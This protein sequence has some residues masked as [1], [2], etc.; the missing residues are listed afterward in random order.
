MARVNFED[1]VEAQDEFW[2]LL[3]LV[4]GD[5]DSALGKLVR[6]FRLA[7]KAY[8]HDRPMT[9]DE[10]RSRGFGIM[11]ES[12]WAV[13]VNGGYQALGAPKHF[14][15]YRQKVLAGKK[16]GRPIEENEEP[17]GNLS[18]PAD[19]LVV[20]TANPLAPAPALALSPAPAQKNKHTHARE[21]I[22]RCIQEWKRTLEHFEIS[23]PIGERD[24]IEIAR[25][26][27]SFGEEWVKLAFQGA[28]K[29]QA[30]KRFDP[31]L[32]VSLR[33]YLHKDRIERLVNIGAGKESADGI[34]W[35]YVFKEGA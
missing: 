15:W 33:I 5:R 19:N 26:V 22:D 32:F 1:D 29:Q 35:A 18:V 27:Q 3:P 31:K 23:R 7:Q 34:D 21:E 11:I 17:N 30:S 9:E 24:Q 2:A 25:A 10:L 4:G 16:G 14:G 12:G 13:P 28:R 8:G 6:F 20:P